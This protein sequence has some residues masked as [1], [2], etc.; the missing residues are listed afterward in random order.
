MDYKLFISWLSNTV[1]VLKE[2]FKFGLPIIV[3]I[4]LAY[5]IDQ[6][7]KERKIIL[8]RQ[9]EH[10]YGPIYYQM[11]LYAIGHINEETFVNNLLDILSKNYI[12]TSFD[13]TD[14][15]LLMQRSMIEEPKNYELFIENYKKL[16]TRVDQRYHDLQKKLGF[17]YG[18]EQLD[19]KKELKKIKFFIGFINF[20]KLAWIVILVISLWINV[21][22]LPSIIMLGYLFF[23][24]MNTRVVRLSSKLE[25][26]DKTLSK[27]E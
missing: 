7:I 8:K 5:Y 17:H 21:T 25:E 9:L 24:K 18:I 3:P 19:T 6:N 26:R 27:F 4:I 10:I 1:D 20:S 22:L 15:I 16:I 13:I 2:I 23:T 12:Y 11:D 14:P